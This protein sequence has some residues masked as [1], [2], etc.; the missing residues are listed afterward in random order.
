MTRAILLT[1]LALALTATLAYAGG[2][3]VFYIWPDGVVVEYD[4]TAPSPADF[5]YT[6]VVDCATGVGRAVLRAGDAYVTVSLPEGNATAWPPAAAEFAKRLVPTVPHNSTGV[7]AVEIVAVNGTAYAR[8]RGCKV[9]ADPADPASHRLAVLY[10]ATLLR[11]VNLTTAR[12]TGMGNVT[13]S[14]AEVPFEAILQM[15][16]WLDIKLPGVGREAPDNKTE[17]LIPTNTT[18]TPINTVTQAPTVAETQT[19]TGNTP[20]T[21]AVSVEYTPVA[22]VTPTTGEVQK[23][24]NG[25]VVMR[26]ALLV[27]LAVALIIAAIALKKL[28]E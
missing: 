26:I 23:S 19:A 2:V 7:L 21:P 3:A 18:M 4:A 9:A 25:D 10:Y 11:S 5:N 22:G 17:V 12:F 15:G 28:K 24:G 16:F 1:T 6:A 14:P 13:V 8:Y 20:T 27:A